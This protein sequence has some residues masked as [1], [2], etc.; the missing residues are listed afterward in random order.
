MVT[1]MLDS[2]IKNDK[3]PGLKKKSVV[4]AQCLKKL[5]VTLNLKILKN[6]N[7]Y[8]N[9]LLLWAIKRYIL[10]SFRKQK[11]NLLKK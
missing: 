8:A 5:I 1:V 11:C 6:K 7:E 4:I 10:S 2:E 3:M 9:I